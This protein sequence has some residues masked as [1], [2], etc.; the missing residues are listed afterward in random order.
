VKGKFELAKQMLKKIRD[1]PVLKT[2]YPI[3]KVKLKPSEFFNSI[4]P[5]RGNFNVD[6]VEFF[7]PQFGQLH[8]K[9]RGYYNEKLEEIALSKK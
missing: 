3:H 8:K 4:A 7:Q 5:S 6:R 9:F 2:K 1:N